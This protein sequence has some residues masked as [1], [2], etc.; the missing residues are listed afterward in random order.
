MVPI[1]HFWPPPGPA[2]LVLSNPVIVPNS[3]EYRL[4]LTNIPQIPRTWLSQIPG[5]VRIL[6]KITWICWKSPS[7]HEHGPFKS[8]DLSESFGV[9]PESDEY[10]SDSAD[11]VVSNP[12]IDPNSLELRLDLLEIPKFPR[13]RFFRIRRSFRI[14]WKF[15]WIWRIFLESRGSDPFKS[16]N[17]FESFGRS[18]RFDGNSPGLRETALFLISN[19]QTKIRFKSFIWKK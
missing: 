2:S 13:T 18:P 7:F 11:L 19:H 4:N 3:L 16:E 8:W 15:T 9:S 6:W 14:L 5:F 17:H 10:S 1:L 12:V